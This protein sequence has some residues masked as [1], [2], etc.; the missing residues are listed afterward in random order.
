VADTSLGGESSQ[1]SRIRVA[2]LADDG[3]AVSGM[4]SREER[5]IFASI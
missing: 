1:K 2:D 4:S 3:K 5:R